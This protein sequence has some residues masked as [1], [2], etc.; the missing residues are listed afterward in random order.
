MRISLAAF[1]FAGFCLLFLDVSG[2]FPQ[3][4]AFL[5]KM[6]FV[7]A[8]LSESFLIVAALVA[9]TLLFGRV[10]CST[11]CPLGVLQDVL[12][13]LGGKRRF[14]FSRNRPWLRTVALLVFLLAF[15]TEAS[16]LFSLLEPYSAFGR[17]AASLLAPFW[18]AGNNILAHVSEWAGNFVVGPAPAREAGAASLAAAGVTLGVVG[19]LA[20]RAGRTWCNTLCPVGAVLGC[21]HRFALFRPRIALDRC[22]R[23]G[24][25]ATTCKAAC[26]DAAHMVMDSS[27]CVA[28]FNCVNNC[29]NQ[30]ISCAPPS[31]SG[32]N[33]AREAAGPDPSRRAFITAGLSLAGFPTVAAARNPD[34]RP[35]DLSP[36]KRPNRE[37]PIAPPGSTGLRA[38]MEHC[39]GCLL[40]ASSC[41]NQ[42]LSAD[43]RGPA[44][45]RPVMSFERGFCRV[46][47]ISC[48]LVCPT[49]AIR[50]IA[51]E[52]R[53][54][55]QVGRAIVDQ[56]RCIVTTDK[57]TCTACFRACPTGAL[58]LAGADGKIK[59][60][61]VDQE[62]CIG[63][64]ACEY[65]CPARPMSA[66]R[67]EGNL[68]HRRV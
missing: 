17:I 61:A 52:L 11:L 35:P 33:T 6:Q 46:N 56:E 29:P 42:V 57:E 26:I 51:K 15:L 16:T 25:C 22:A 55:I 28:C 39:T 13:R 27:R 54:S 68:E 62:R 48:S 30:A 2:F 44:A 40:C 63:C 38:F 1:C 67:V 12:S 50:P 23:C 49:G 4:L 5:A 41:P 9:L 7:P 60:P 37:T 64:G 20:V 24:A 45:L 47:C 59:R 8:L 14:R 3:K 31:R 21:L 10:F 43:D 36:K 34:D 19:V 18:L 58:A 53:S 66:I 32:P 65:V